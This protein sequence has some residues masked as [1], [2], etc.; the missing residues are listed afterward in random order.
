MER[1][2]EQA[3]GDRKSLHN[4]EDV[5]EVLFLEGEQFS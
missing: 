2:I 1:R 5:H 4:I 3:N